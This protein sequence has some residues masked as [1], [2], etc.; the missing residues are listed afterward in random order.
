MQTPNST[1]RRPTAGKTVQRIP[2]ICV[3]DT[4]SDDYRDWDKTAGA[5]GARMVSVGT[6]AEA[7][8]LARSQRIDLWVINGVL[9]GL[10]GYE[11]CRMLKLHSPSATISIVTDE[12]S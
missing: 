5:S 2:T 6:A 10:S 11:L 9:P 7:L 8:R 12:Y 1:L 3:V 4:R